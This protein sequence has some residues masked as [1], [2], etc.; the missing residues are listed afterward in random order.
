LIRTIVRRK[1]FIYA[2]VTLLLPLLV[3]FVVGK[4]WP[5]FSFRVGETVIEVVPEDI[6][7]RIQVFP[8]YFAGQLARVPFFNPYVSTF[9]GIL[10]NNA[11]LLTILILL[12]LVEVLEEYVL[13]K[14][15]RYKEFSKN[16]NDSLPNF[17][18]PYAPISII[19][20]ILQGVVAGWILSSFPLW[21]IFNMPIVHASIE[22]LAYILAI[23]F[24]YEVHLQKNLTS[25]TI[26]TLYKTGKKYFAITYLLLIISALIETNLIMTI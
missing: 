6:A 26:I 3:G 10:T 19:F 15:N 12:P 14:S 23:A 21:V 16:V 11:L 7:E 18:Q 9:L 1:A 8:E 4:V 20:G 22:F 25:E 24:L 5:S 13:N 2:T 17:P